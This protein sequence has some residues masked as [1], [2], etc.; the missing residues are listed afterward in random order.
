[1]SIATTVGASISVFE[2]RAAD[3]WMSEDLRSGLDGPKWTAPTGGRL[4]SQSHALQDI[5]LQELGS[6]A[7]RKPLAPEPTFSAASLAGTARKLFTDLISVVADGAADD[8]AAEE[9]AADDDGSDSGS[10]SEDSNP[11][12]RPLTRTQSVLQGAQSVLADFVPRP[13]LFQ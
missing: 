6:T 2:L 12:P 3:C 11:T 5:P 10:L 7:P 1:M 4:R 8:G 13:E 9:S